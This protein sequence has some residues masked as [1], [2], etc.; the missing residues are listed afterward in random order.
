MSS[1]DAYEMSKHIPL[2]IG[3]TKNEFATFANGRFFGASEE[4]VMKHIEQTYKDKASAYIAAV[5]KAY[6]ND[7]QPHD[8]L[9]VDTMFRPGTVF[10]ANKKATVV[11][12]AKVYMYLFTWQSPVFDGKYQ[13]VHCME[14]PFVFDNIELARNMTGGG[15]QA[16][17]LA[18]RVSKAWIHFAKTGNPNHSGLPEWPAYT[19]ENTATMHFDLNCEVKPQLDKELFELISSL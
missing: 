5:R 6:P 16:H 10:Q 19:P 3:T 4:T 12:G 1:D 13:S 14:L 7:T 2:L 9:T 11:D 17:A 8:L 15:I 18:D